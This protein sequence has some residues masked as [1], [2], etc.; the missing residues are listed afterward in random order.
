MA[1]Y[2]YILLC[3]DGSYYTGYTHDLKTRMEQHSKGQGSKY[4]RM[5]KL[6]RIV[7]FEWFNTRSGAMKREREIKRFT[8]KKKTA[9][10]NE[11][12]GGPQ[13]NEN[14]L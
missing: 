4:T 10:I 11:K 9:L 5:K 1:Y 6:R 7:Y 12:Q 3:G 8:H 2:V 14:N 13:S